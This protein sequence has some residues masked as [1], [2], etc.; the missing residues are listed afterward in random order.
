MIKKIGD[1]IGRRIV[2]TGLGL[3]TCFGNDLDFIWEQLMKGESGV[4]SIDSFDT[5]E[6]GC[7]IAAP[8]RYG[9]AKGEIDLDK[10][11]VMECEYSHPFKK[12]IP[13]KV[14]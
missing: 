8:I 11:I 2:V 7:K 13:I 3:A 5:S 4:R 14:V 6:L 9:Q 10:F 12:W 1:L